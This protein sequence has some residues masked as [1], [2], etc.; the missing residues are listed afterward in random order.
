MNNILSDT[1]VDFSK[2]KVPKNWSKMTKIW[3]FVS[4]NSF[5]SHVIERH[6]QLTRLLQEANPS[7]F[8]MRLIEY[9]SILIRSFMVDFAL[10]ESQPIESLCFQFS[11]VLDDK[12]L[13]E[14]D[15]EQ[16]CLK[17][18]KVCLANAEYVASLDLSFY[19]DESVDGELIIRKSVKNLKI[20][21]F[22]QVYSL[23]AKVVPISQR[24]TK[25]FNVPMYKNA[26]TKTMDVD[27]KVAEIEDGETK[28]FVWSVPIATQ[29]AEI[30]LQQNGTSLF[31]RMPEQFI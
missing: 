4:V 6:A 23:V 31:C 27:E 19:D 20:C 28:N 16:R 25:V 9:P 7:T 21:P 10:R 5:A 12:S 18:N 22:K 26:I 29:V 8:D 2:G 15:R 30:D 24:Q 14:N 17:M 1:G 3:N 11:I 13:F